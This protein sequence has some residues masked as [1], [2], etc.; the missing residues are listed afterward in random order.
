MADHKEFEPDQ[1]V[2]IIPISCTFKS[3]I[4]LLPKMRKIP[5]AKNTNA[6]CWLNSSIVSIAFSRTLREW[7]E[8]NVPNAGTHMF[9]LSQMLK[10]Y[11]KSL[12][13]AMQ[14]KN[15]EADTNLNSLRDMQAYWMR[16]EYGW[17]IGIFQSAWQFI[18]CRLPQ[19]GTQGFELISHSFHQKTVCNN[20]NCCIEKDHSEASIFVSS[21]EGSMLERL[22]GPIPLLDSCSSCNKGK[23]TSSYNFYKAP[24]LLIVKIDN[25]NSKLSDLM[26]VKAINNGSTV[27]QYNLSS[28]ICYRDSHFT[29]YV[30]LKDN[31]AVYFN[32]VKK[33]AK[34]VRFPPSNSF[35]NLVYMCLY[36]LVLCHGS[37]SPI[38]EISIT[39]S[40][41][42]NIINNNS[43]QIGF[44]CKDL[45][46]KEYHSEIDDV[47]NRLNK[48]SLTIGNERDNSEQFISDIIQSSHMN[49]NDN[50]NNY[51]DIIDDNEP[52]QQ[53]YGQFQS[54]S[55]ANDHAISN[56]SDEMD[57][58]HSNQNSLDHYIDNM[59]NSACNKDSIDKNCQNNNDFEEQINAFANSVNDF[60]I[61]PVSYKANRPRSKPDRKEYISKKR[62]L[63]KE[64]EVLRPKANAKLLSNDS[65]AETLKYICKCPRTDCLRDLSIHQLIELRKINLA[66]TNKALTEY[67]V[68]YMA[69]N[70]KS[71][72]KTKFHVKDDI[73][74]CKEAFMRAYGIGKDRITAARRIFKNGNTISIRVKPL[75]RSCPVEEW[76]GGWLSTFFESNCDQV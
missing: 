45:A 53:Q 63:K 30:I 4:D 24:K 68:Q 37:D 52:Q 42:D 46:F 1:E 70:K 41:T 66:K 18:K 43:S 64:I 11:D 3:P 50:N 9:G 57:Q 58:K 23:I 72:G 7:F 5:C 12:E 59:Y 21:A 74:C 36:E 51:N 25:G 28:I 33:V 29:N 15:S 47:I 40:N 13:L 35:F 76:V 2:E 27:G 71:N 39:P 31:K 32:D 26:A 60:T 55:A 48:L 10:S 38:Q 54:E 16:S 22:Y 14:G 75:D 73:E 61:G 20:C 49:S 69:L 19:P 67:F 56:G 6:L 8:Y 44:K 17:N 65:L 34:I 62:K